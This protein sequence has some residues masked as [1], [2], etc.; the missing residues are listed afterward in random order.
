M[1]IN[2]TGRL[3]VSLYG[4]LIQGC[5]HNGNLR[6][7]GSPAHLPVR[8]GKGSQGR[9]AEGHRGRGRG[10]SRERPVHRGNGGEPGARP[11]ALRSSAL[12]HSGVFLPLPSH[13]ALLRRSHAPILFNFTHVA[14]PAVRAS[15]LRNNGGVHGA[16]PPP[17]LRSGRPVIIRL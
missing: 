6:H 14:R 7:T 2:Y 11:L 9:T 5:R 3:A 13:L 17:P 10:A 12:Q 1:D 8:R 16:A 15:I 4:I